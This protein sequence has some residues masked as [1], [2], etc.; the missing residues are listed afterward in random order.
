[1]ERC[2]AAFSARSERIG[3]TYSFDDVYE[4]LSGNGVPKLV[5]F[6]SDFDNFS[7]YSGLF[8]EKF[9]ESHV[10]GM[11][12]DCIFSSEGCSDTGLS[13][14]AI[15]SGIECACG[16]L[17]EA[18]RCPIKYIKNALEAI[19]ELGITARDSDRVCCLEF[20]ACAE[21]NEELVLDTFREARGSSRQI[22][23]FG[24]SAAQRRGTER[25]YVSLD[26]D[27]Y[28]DE[29][30]FVYIRNL[31]GRIS[32][33]SENTYRPS[34]K[35]FTA[36]DVDCDSKTVYEFN[37][38]PAAAYLASLIDAEVP[39][40]ARD[41]ARYPVG[42]I[43]D[44]KI[45]I[46]TGRSVGKDASITFGSTVYNYSDTVLL[47]P[48]D[49]RTVS[50]RFIADIDDL[51][52]KPSFSLA[53]NCAFNYD[54][55]ADTGRTGTFAK[56]LAD[57]AGVFTGVSGRSEQLGCANITKTMLLAAFE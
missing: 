8:R 3:E 53:V 37:E 30:V 1:M 57:K 29:S 49:P 46:A 9:P 50:D 38:R 10:I 42:R 27:V 44:G 43:Y 40:V 15:Y 24:S 16:V 47:E 56:R 14:L 26:G 12:T 4:R 51:G 5:I 35:Y 55:F 52:F 23:L 33:I 25:S 17:H 18:G 48:D 21:Y 13:A 20:T 39:V 31:N 22:T 45:Y 54:L 6:S 28:E 2:I 7:L 34:G 11:S 32:V 41:I 36:T 19:D